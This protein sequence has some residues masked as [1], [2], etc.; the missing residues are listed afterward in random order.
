MAVPRFSGATQQHDVFRGF[1]FRISLDNVE[2]AACNKC[3]GL[4]AA[5]EVCHFRAGNSQSTADELTPGRVTFEPI[6]LEAGITTDTAFKDWANMLVHHAATPTAPVV[7]G[8]A[9]RGGRTGAAGLSSGSALETDSNPERPL[10]NVQ[11]AATPRR[12][13]SARRRDPGATRQVRERLVRDATNL[14]LHDECA[15]RSDDSRWSPRHWAPL[16]TPIGLRPSAAFLSSTGNSGT[17]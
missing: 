15:G 5:I 17:G 2:V 3:S 12:C 10:L 8:T 1:N 4:T 9:V 6:T 16:A 13:I 7:Q 14:R 11:A